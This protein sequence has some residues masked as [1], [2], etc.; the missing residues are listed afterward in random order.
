M[1]L[2][3]GGDLLINHIFILKKILKYVHVHGDSKRSFSRGDIKENDGAVG[4]L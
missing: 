1:N 3:K 4:V 2:I